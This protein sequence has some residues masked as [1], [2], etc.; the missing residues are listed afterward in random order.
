MHHAEG[1][2]FERLLHSR[3]TN[4]R[5]LELHWKVTVCKTQSQTLPLATDAGL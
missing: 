1:C 5:Q 2:M 3:V 4:R